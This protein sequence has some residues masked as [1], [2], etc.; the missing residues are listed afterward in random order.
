M[1]SNIET[2]RH[3]HSAGIVR[4]GPLLVEVLLF[5]GYRLLKEIAETCLLIFGK[6]MTSLKTKVH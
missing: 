3:S 1:S 6:L 5:G 4:S 2:T